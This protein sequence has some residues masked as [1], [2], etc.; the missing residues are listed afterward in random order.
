VSQH[1][2]LQLHERGLK[3]LKKRI[4]KQAVR[5]RACCNSGLFQQPQA[6]ALTTRKESATTLSPNL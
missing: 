5:R 1:R 6:I 4:T 2:S 3:K